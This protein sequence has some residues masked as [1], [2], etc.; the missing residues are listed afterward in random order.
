[1]LIGSL[2]TLAGYM[3]AILTTGGLTPQNATAQPD[4]QVIDEIICKRLRVVD[5][6]GKPSV[7]VQSSFNDGGRIRIYNKQRDVGVGIGSDTIYLQNINGK[8]SIA[9]S[10]HVI[11]GHI[12]VRNNKGN[13]AIDIAGF[14]TGGEIGIYNET[15]NTIARLGV[16]ES[17]GGLLTIY[18]EAGKLGSEISADAFGGAFRLYNEKE[19]IG[20]NIYTLV[21][22][23]LSMY[24]EAGKSVVSIG[25]DDNGNGVIQSYKGGWR[26]H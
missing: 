9:I 12:R 15:K 20:V 8:E 5:A 24:N 13:V 19:K 25:A 3:L 14:D 26:T 17:Q 16:A 10:A 21:G 22:S 6:D 4:T 18:N 7:V 1:M 11:G 2:F 23:I